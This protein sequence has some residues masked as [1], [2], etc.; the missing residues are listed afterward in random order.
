MKIYNN[1]KYVIS[2]LVVVIIF[3]SVFGDKVTTWYLALIFLSMLVINYKNI[4]KG[5]V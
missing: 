3:Q 2:F 4:L 5:V 1:L